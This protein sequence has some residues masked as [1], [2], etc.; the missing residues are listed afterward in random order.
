MAD[1]IDDASALEEVFRRSAIAKATAPKYVAAAGNNG[2]CL[3]C[4]APIG[5]KRLAA[6][7]HAVLCIDCAREAER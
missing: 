2:L 1:I 5:E 4:D 3:S 7:P 6:N